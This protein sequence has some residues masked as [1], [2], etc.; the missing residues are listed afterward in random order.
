MNTWWFVLA[1]NGMACV[2]GKN[3][4]KTEMSMWTPLKECSS[5]QVKVKCL[6]CVSEDGFSIA[7]SSCPWLCPFV[8]KAGEP[9]RRVWT[10]AVNRHSGVSS[11]GRF[12]PEMTGQG[13]MW[14]Q[15]IVKLND[16][17]CCHRITQARWPSDLPEN[18]STAA[19]SVLWGPPSIFLKCLITLPDWGGGGCTKD[20]SLHL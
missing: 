15:S 6:Q 19:W 9:C 16:S 8:N 17:N 20:V 2:W 3:T 7:G 4:Q 14:T 18:I 5:F 13:N 10:A 12:C 1:C 11:K